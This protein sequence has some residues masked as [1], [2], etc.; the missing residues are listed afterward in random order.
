ML[1]CDVKVQLILNILCVNRFWFENEKK[2]KKYKKKGDINGLYAKRSDLLLGNAPNYPNC[3]THYSF[4]SAFS[5]MQTK[6]WQSLLSC[7]IESH[8]ARFIFFLLE[9]SMLQSKSSDF[10]LH[11]EE[12]AQVFLNEILKK[13]VY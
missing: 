11:G 4:P 10:A 1:W 9:V 12:I 3:S 2:K 13:S 8:L 6:R 5:L 7:F